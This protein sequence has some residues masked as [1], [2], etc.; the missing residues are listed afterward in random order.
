MSLP[1]QER[2]GSHEDLLAATEELRRTKLAMRRQEEDLQDRRVLVC[3]DRW[4]LGQGC[5]NTW[6]PEKLGKRAEVNLA[7]M[8]GNHQMVSFGSAILFP[9]QTSDP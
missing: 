4:V 2:V 8:V 5:T 3:R 1:L 9:Q 6:N 7:E